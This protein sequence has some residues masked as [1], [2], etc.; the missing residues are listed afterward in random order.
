[1]VLELPGVIGPS[2]PRTL[3]VKIKTTHAGEELTKSRMSSVIHQAD[4][5]I[6]QA[7]ARAASNLESEYIN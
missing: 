4:F 3:E 1:M 7:L 2:V 5:K 6:I